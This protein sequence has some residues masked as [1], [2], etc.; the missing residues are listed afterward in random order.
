[1]RIENLTRQINE[2]TFAP[3][4]KCDLYIPIEPL[5]DFNAVRNDDEIALFLGRQLLQ[6]L[7]EKRP[8]TY[9]TPA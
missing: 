7:L 2:E 1:M 8:T 3:E 4:Y 6:Q 9:R 5:Q